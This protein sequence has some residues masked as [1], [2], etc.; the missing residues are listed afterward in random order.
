MSTR[1]NPTLKDWGSNPLEQNGAKHPRRHILGLN[2][3]G[4]FSFSVTEA[5]QTVWKSDAHPGVH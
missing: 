1:Q 5:K 3:D 2:R 4:Y